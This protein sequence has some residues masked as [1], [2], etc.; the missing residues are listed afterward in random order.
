MSNL[1]NRIGS[2]IIIEKLHLNKTKA[3]KTVDSAVGTDLEDAKLDVTVRLYFELWIM[4]NDLKYTWDFY[5][6]Q[7][8]NPG[9]SEILFLLRKCQLVGGREGR[10]LPAPGLV[11]VHLP[12][13]L[14][15]FLPGVQMNINRPAGQL[16]TNKHNSR[17]WLQCS[18]FG[19]FCNSTADS[20]SA[21]HCCSVF[22]VANQSEASLQKIFQFWLVRDWIWVLVAE[23]L[24]SVTTR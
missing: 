15:H 21:I 14:Y 8:V 2:N 12:L 24:T 22:C 4:L 18:K 5:Y 9:S 19:K 3:G 17:V 13:T 16:L 20:L 7:L 1:S 10:A 6:L 11:N 23:W